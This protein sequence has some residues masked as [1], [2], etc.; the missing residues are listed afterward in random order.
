MADIKDVVVG[1]VERTEKRELD[2]GLDYGSTCWTVQYQD[3][4]FGVYPD[5]P[6]LAIWWE[7]GGKNRSQLFDGADVKPLADLLGDKF[8][9]EEVTADD[10]IKIALKCL[11][12][13]G[14]KN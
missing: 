13:E 4:R 1:L 10:A 14:N 2:W 5:L 7:R 8:P 12:E 6:R 3:C 9:F 11:S